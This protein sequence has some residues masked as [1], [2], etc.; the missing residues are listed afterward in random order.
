MSCVYHFQ[1]FNQRRKKRGDRIIYP[2]LHEL[3]CF[4]LIIFDIMRSWNIFLGLSSSKSL[5]FICSYIF[6]QKFHLFTDIFLKHDGNLS[7]FSSFFFSWI[8]VNFQNAPPLD[9]FEYDLKWNSVPVVYIFVQ[10]CKGDS[11]ILISMG[12]LL[13]TN[14]D[15]VLKFQPAFGNRFVHKLVDCRVREG[16]GVLLIRLGGL[17]GG[18]YVHY[19]FSYS[20]IH[21]QCISMCTKRNLS[22][23]SQVIF[24]IYRNRKCTKLKHTCQEI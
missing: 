16:V 4:F 9:R 23:L 10:W 13:A 21:I 12:W 8:I 5:S 2:P 19:Q 6:Q 15:V 7:L 20:T 22:Q 11:L 3:N 24:A 1:L 18:G 17:M 14:C